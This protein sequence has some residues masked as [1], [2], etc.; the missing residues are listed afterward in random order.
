MCVSNMLTIALIT[1][2]DVILCW[3]WLF[4]DYPKLSQNYYGLLECLA[5]DHMTFISNLEPQVFLYILSTISEGLTALGMYSASFPHNTSLP[6]N[7]SSLTTTVPSH[8]P[9]SVC[10]VMLDLVCTFVA[11]VPL[12]VHNWYEIFVS[13]RY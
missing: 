6:N 10:L 3:L 12:Q 11:S 4:Q 8:H 2:I 7:N 9:M 5:Q 1:R 13:I